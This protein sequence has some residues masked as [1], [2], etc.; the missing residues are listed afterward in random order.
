MEKSN[1]TILDLLGTLFIG[2]KLTGN[3]TWSWVWVLLPLWL[4]IS[5]VLL[6]GIMYAL[7][8]ALDEV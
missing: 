3:I 4:P 8:K 7:K 1:I 6:V 2:L 5:V